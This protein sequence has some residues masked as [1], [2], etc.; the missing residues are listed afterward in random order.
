MSQEHPHWKVALRNA[1]HEAKKNNIRQVD[2]RRPSSEVGCRWSR[3]GLAILPLMMMAYTERRLVIRDSVWAVA[4]CG[5]APSRA[6]LA[7]HSSTRSNRRPR[8]SAICGD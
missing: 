8:V 7:A 5:R 3:Q 1:A 6:S 2:E 4:D